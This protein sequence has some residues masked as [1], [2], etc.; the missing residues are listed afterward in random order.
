MSRFLKTLRLRLLQIELDG[1]ERAGNT[2]RARAIA[3]REALLRAE[4]N[5]L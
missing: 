1:F 3:P 5:H 2:K 4:L